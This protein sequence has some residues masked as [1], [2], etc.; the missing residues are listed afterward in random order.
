MKQMIGVFLGLV[1]GLAGGMAMAN[2]EGNEATARAFIRAM[3]KMDFDL[4]LELV[5][6]DVEYV[7]GPA[8]AVLGAAGIRQTLEPF[9]APIEEN[10]FLI[11]NSASA[12]AVVFIERLDRHRVANGWFELPV[13][14]V[15]EFQNNKIVKWREYFDL[16]TIRSDMGRLLGEQ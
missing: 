12:G 15:F 10:E 13:N 16:S 5:S 11:R 2:D 7:N 9:F 14:S 3:E 4:A 1:L 6:E 8:P